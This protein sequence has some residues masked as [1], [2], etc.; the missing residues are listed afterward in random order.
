[1]TDRH[2]LILTNDEVLALEKLLRA[3]VITDG[4]RDLLRSKVDTLLE[5]EQTREYIQKTFGIWREQP[6]S[7]DQAYRVTLT[8]VGKVSEIFVVAPSSE[9]AYR[10]AYTYFCQNNIG[11][12]E[13]RKTMCIEPL[14]LA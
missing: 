6:E 13:S 8:R 12:S 9:D 4:E 1:M 3:G 7:S 10:K 2:V 5:I 11:D 14:P